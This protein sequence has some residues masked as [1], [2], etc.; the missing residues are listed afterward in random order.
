MRKNER[1]AL[2]ESHTEKAINQRLL[3]GPKKSYLRDF[4]YGAIDGTVTTFAV[5]AGATGAHFSSTVIIILGF[6]NLIA[7]GFSMGISNFLGTKAEKE[8]FLKTKAEEEYHIAMVPEGEREE[9]RHIFAKKGFHGEDLEKIVSTLTSDVKLWVDTMLKEEHK[10]TTIPFSPVWA[11]SIT[12]LAFISLG[13]FPLLPFVVAFNA[14]FFWSALLAGLTF[15][16]IGACKSFFTRKS[17]Y[18]SGL[19]SFLVGG[20]AAVLAYLIGFTLKQFI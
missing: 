1:E 10:L 5:V 19:E 4:I 17:W 13:F 12:F 14:T 3:K 6:A 11:G 7:D 16:T 8:L 2:R 20:C 18:L 15:F 9:L